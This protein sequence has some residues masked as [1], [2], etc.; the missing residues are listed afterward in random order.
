[1]LQQLCPICEGWKLA[2]LKKSKES[3]MSDSIEYINRILKDNDKPSV[4][5]KDNKGGKTMFE[6]ETG[7][8]LCHYCD[9]EAT[10][11]ITGIS[12]M[13]LCDDA[14]CAKECLY[15]EMGEEPIDY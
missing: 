15:N 10:I 5:W 9:D 6:D 11:N 12:D 7:L 4:Y 3:K 2:S 1:M 14:E 13:Y 8:I